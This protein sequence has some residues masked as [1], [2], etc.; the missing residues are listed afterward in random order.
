MFIR[1][2]LLITAFAFSAFAADHVIG[3]W[4]LNNTKSKYVGIPSPKDVIVTYTPAGAGWKYEGKGT[5]ADGQP[6]NMTFTYV[7][8]GEDMPLTGYP[9]ADTLVLRNGKSDTSTGTFKRGGKAIGTA[10]R[11]ISK[12]GKTMTIDAKLTLPDGKK[13][14][15]LAVYDKQ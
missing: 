7:K 4:K 12:D 13:G 3:T 10:K 15:Y 6:I 5:A 2:A 8:D 1:S 14:S 11:T 9:N